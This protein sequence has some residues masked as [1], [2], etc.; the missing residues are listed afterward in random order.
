M[1]KTGPLILAA[2]AVGAAV[3]ILGKGKA[4]G[5]DGDVMVAIGTD[6]EPLPTNYPEGTAITLMGGAVGSGVNIAHLIR[7][8]VSIDDLPFVEFPSA[9]A[10][11][12]Y[13]IPIGVGKVTIKIS[14]TDPQTGNSDTTQYGFTVLGETPVFNPPEL[15]VSPRGGTIEVGESINF[16]AS[17]FAD[18]VRQD[19]SSII[20]WWITWPNQ[21]VKLEQ[22]GP[23]FVLT[24]PSPGRVGIQVLVRD[25]ETQLQA[26]DGFSVDVNT[27]TVIP[28][29]LAVNTPPLNV[30]LGDTFLFT[31]Q[32][33]GPS[34]DIS[35]NVEWWLGA[36]GAPFFLDHFG[37][38]YMAVF[39]SSG[40]HLIEAR[41]VDGLVQK[42]FQVSVNVGDPQPPPAPLTPVVINVNNPPINVS[43]GTAFTFIAE[44]FGPSG[45]LSDSVTWRLSRNGEPFFNVFFG[46]VYTHAFNT[47][48]FTL[49]EASVVDGVDKVLIQKAVNVIADAPPAALSISMTDNVPASSPTRPFPGVFVGTA[50]LGGVDVSNDIIWW[51]S[52]NNASFFTVFFGKSWSNTFGGAGAFRVQARITKEGQT[53]TVTKSFFVVDPFD[54]DVF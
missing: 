11:F 34:G 46:R 39:N 19:L 25:P 43:L 35:A 29:T 6:G 53:Q 50:E 18:V 13:T 44:A 38:Q 7:W 23:T 9:G 2:A 5:D 49:I 3:L 42:I 17:A 31:A 45:D 8:S 54:P 40:T 4:Q 1:V 12:N 21:L 41:V 48:G 24:P 51:L 27:G 26:S 36:S 37:R 32:A 28:V 52:E 33:S 20:E 14:V 30:D 22:T 16:T 15:N 47:P 10:T